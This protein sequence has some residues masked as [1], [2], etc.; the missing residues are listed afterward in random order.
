MSAPTELKNRPDASSNFKQQK[1]PA[2]QP[3][4]SAPWVISCFFFLAVLF[5]PI[6]G[7][8]V[9][10]SDGVQEVI[11]RYDDLG[12]CY[13]WTPRVS[14]TP[15]MFKQN[16]DNQA[17]GVVSA[18]FNIPARMK[19]PVYI[20]YAMENFYQNHRKYAK[21]KSNLQLRGET[22]SLSE[23]GID[24][25]PFT[26]PDQFSGLSGQVK[27]DNTAASQIVEL[28]AVAY[29][30]CG[31]IAWSMFNDSINLELMSAPGAAGQPTGLPICAGEYFN[32]V[33]VKDQSGNSLV[34]WNAN[35]EKQG[36][37]WESDINTKYVRPTVTGAEGMSHLT[38][39]GWPAAPDNANGTDLPLNSFARQGWYFG[40]AG[41]KLPNATD[42]DFMVWNRLAAMSSFRKLY[43]K[44]TVDLLPG[45]YRFHIAQRYP[46]RSFEGK[47]F[48]IIT[49]GSVLGG[50][51]YFLGGV[52][53]CMGAVCLLLSVAFAAYY[54]LKMRGTTV[55]GRGF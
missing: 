53:L 2:W 6:G 10:I 40:E 37:A 24:C 21:S 55:G 52:Y 5:L 39:A 36:I 38:R 1:L 54:F 31:L 22:R 25:D 3:V 44:I 48:A 14:P 16:R 42:L 41:H 50:K 43:R 30:P 51:N 47:K 9:A 33:G 46:V 23:L 8:I 12:D 26:S 13:P 4:M 29:N 45:D 19:Q 18:Y 17:C 27:F 34:V 7:A 32:E 35:C 49:T 11:V 28:N 15:G 20:Y